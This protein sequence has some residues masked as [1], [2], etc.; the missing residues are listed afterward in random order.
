M[1]TS[2]ICE[3]GI[4]SGDPANKFQVDKVGL[5]SLT[6]EKMEAGLQSRPGNEMAGVEGRTQLLVRLANALEEKKDFFGTDGR[7]GNM[8]GKFSSPA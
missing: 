7:P 5:R 1:D 6:V 3:Q 4:F 2:L 8:V